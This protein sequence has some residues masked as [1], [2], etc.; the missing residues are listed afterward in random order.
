MGDLQKPGHCVI[1]IEV[2]L[3]KNPSWTLPLLITYNC[4]SSM[5]FTFAI[6]HL[7]VST[8]KYTLI[9]RTSDSQKQPAG[10]SC[11]HVWMQFL[12]NSKAKIILACRTK[13]LK[14]VWVRQKSSTMTIMNMHIKIQE[15]WSC[16][17]KACSAKN[18]ENR[19]AKEQYRKLRG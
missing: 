9:Q 19:E 13:T 11:Y 1:R 3:V 4:T 5:Q 6:S 2:K 15:R 16:Y 8:K 14:V 7:L 10:I 18:I 17:A 12:Y